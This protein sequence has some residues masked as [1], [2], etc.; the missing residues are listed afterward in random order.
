MDLLTDLQ[1]VD[2]SS[3]IPGGYCA[4]LLGDAGADVVKIEPPDGDPLRRWTN[5]GY[6][7]GADPRAD[8][9]GGALFQF[10]HH[11]DPIAKSGQGIAQRAVESLGFSRLSRRDVGQKADAV[12]C[13]IAAAAR[14]GAEFE[15]G[16]ARAGAAHAELN[17][18]TDPRTVAIVGKCPTIDV[19]VFGIDP[20]DEFRVAHA[21]IGL[22][23][24]EQES[25]F[26]GQLQY[27]ARKIEIENPLVRR[28]DRVERRL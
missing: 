28:G 5:Q 25:G 23:K 15:P 17:A 6:W 2:C 9:G 7:A 14:R 19:A 26:A 12:A 21:R 11:A 1:V 16:N 18:K 3:G 8:D 4:K 20:G 13:H 22:R 10:L 24:A 27:V